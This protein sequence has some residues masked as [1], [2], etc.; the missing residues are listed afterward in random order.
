MLQTLPTY[1]ALGIALMIAGVL[2]VLLGLM[3]RAKGLQTAGGQEEP[4]SRGIILIGP[5][6]IVW[7]FGARGRIIALMSFVI[8]I[9][10][11]LVLF[12]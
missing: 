7:G 10:V 1:A 9:I 4:R 12:L 2:I 5:I 11:W 6:P 8:V 3:I